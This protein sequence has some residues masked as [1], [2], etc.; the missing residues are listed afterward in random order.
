[1]VDDDDD[2]LMLVDVTSKGNKYNEKSK[3]IEQSE[4]KPATTNS[5]VEV[6]MAIEGRIKV[7]VS[8]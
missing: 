8:L 6:T 1:M 4:T 3:I 5:I 2:R 7:A